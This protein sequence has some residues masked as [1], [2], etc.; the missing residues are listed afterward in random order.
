MNTI[1][2][3]ASDE[4]EAFIRQQAATRNT[5]ISEYI[6]T[7]FEQMKPKR[8]SRIIKRNGRYVACLPPGC[9]PITDEDVRAEEE[10]YLN[11]R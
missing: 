7:T 11:S 9:R 10:E 5:S 1:A 4:L 6:R 3:K 2:F 8:G